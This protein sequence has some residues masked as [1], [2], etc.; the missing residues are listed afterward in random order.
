LDIVRQK[1]FQHVC[2]LIEKLRGLGKLPDIL[3]YLRVLPGQFAELRYKMRVR[4]KPN[5]EHEVCLRRNA[6][7]ETK[8]G[9]GDRQ[10]LI[11]LLPLELRVDMGSKFMNVE[12]RR[13]EH[14][15]RHIANRVQSL[16]LGADRLDHGIRTPHRMRPPRLGKTS[17]QSILARL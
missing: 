13:I 1:K 5:V 16:P 2:R 4:Q 15:V 12:L 7:L 17:D 11:A 3:C 10:V 14:D 6:V 9:R 8:T